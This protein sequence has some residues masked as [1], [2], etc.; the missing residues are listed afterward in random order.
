MR[1]LCRTQGYNF[2]NIL[3]S[4]SKW[5]SRLT[6]QGEGL[7]SGM[8]VPRPKRANE[9]HWQP[10]RGSFPQSRARK[11]APGGGACV[12]VRARSAPRHSSSEATPILRACSVSTLSDRWRRAGLDKETAVGWRAAAGGGADAPQRFLV[13]CCAC[14]RGWSAGGGAARIRSGGR[15]GGGWVCRQ[16]GGRSQAGLGQGRNDPVLRRAVGLAVGCA[17]RP[18]PVPVSG[19]QLL[20]GWGRE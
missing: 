17:V 8:S 3:G 16:G 19:A 11:G 18:L 6:I 12:S 14:A 9:I 7:E 4:S 20:Q 15:R 2:R 10:G 13:P 1:E 5:R